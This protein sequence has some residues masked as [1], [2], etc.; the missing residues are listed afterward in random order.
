[1]E[2]L[3]EPFPVWGLGYDTTGGEVSSGSRICV[4][5]CDYKLIHIGVI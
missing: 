1:M 4:T 5:I 2:Y 3:K